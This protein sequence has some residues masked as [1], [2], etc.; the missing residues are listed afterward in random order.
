MAAL[1]TRR[2]RPRSVT[3]DVGEAEMV[4]A[5]SIGM[6]MEI[7]TFRMLE[8]LSCRCEPICTCRWWERWLA[9]HGYAD[10]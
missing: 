4:D 7:E 6:T 2:V 8:R 9:D 3:S 5:I 10:A 1:D